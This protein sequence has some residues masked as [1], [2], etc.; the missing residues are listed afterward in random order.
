MY[1]QYTMLL[2]ST[3]KWAFRMVR[4]QNCQQ[5]DYYLTLKT[6][7]TQDSPHAIHAC[8]QNTLAMWETTKA[9]AYQIRHLD[10]LE[11]KNTKFKS[12]TIRPYGF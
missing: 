6:K 11:N 4:L 5:Q 3:L 2:T 10:L 8:T 12:Y 9:Q 1:T 7:G